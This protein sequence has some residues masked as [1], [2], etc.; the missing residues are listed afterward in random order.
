MKTKDFTFDLPKELIAQHPTAERGQSRLMVLDRVTGKRIHSKVVD[1]PEILSEPQL[2][3]PSGAKPILV[4]NDSKV[5][6]ARLVGKSQNSGTPAEFLLLEKKYAP[7][8]E[9]SVWK[10]MVKRAARKKPDD[11]Y[12]FFDDTGA[13]IAGAQIT[14][15]EDECRFL[16]FDRVI[17]DDWLERYGHMPLPPYIKREDAPDDAKRYQTVYAKN[18]GSAAAPTAG[19]HFTE[20]LLARLAA[21]GIDS[22]F[23]TLHVGL[24]TFLPVR[25]ENIQ[26][27]SMHEELFII[28]DESAAKIEKAKAEQ[29]KVIAVGTTCIRC[30]ESAWSEQGGLKRGEQSTSIFIYPSFQ[31][32]AVDAIF[33]NFHTPESTLLMLVS[34]FAGRELILESYNEAVREK[35][36]FFSYG[37]AMLIR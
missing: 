30:L 3:S 9:P 4:F 14:D 20:E 12:V 35:Y 11:R 17:D 1:L 36:R 10:A 2:L 16:Q 19:L 31:F 23:I 6:K 27:H 25:A 8:D 24:G 21:G 29:Q 22:V 34:A 33:T 37:D 13:E 15:G 5:R 28:T 32:K 18:T 7:A 26:D